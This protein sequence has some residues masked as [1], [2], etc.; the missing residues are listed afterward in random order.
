MS[1]E[2]FTNA[3][4]ERIF[5]NFTNMNSVRDVGQFWE[6]I[7]AEDQWSTEDFSF[8]DR[9]HVVSFGT[10]NAAGLLDAVSTY[11]EFGRPTFEVLKILGIRGERVAAGLVRV[12]LP[13]DI[14]N[15]WIHVLELDR[16]LQRVRRMVQFDPDDRHAAIAELDRIHAEIDDETDTPS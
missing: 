5:T 7:T 15:E 8:D 6:S 2:P 12:Q 11:W 3:A 9:R 14:V 10:T 1:D 13:S 16:T 4:V